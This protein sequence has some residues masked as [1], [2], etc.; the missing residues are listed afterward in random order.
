MNRRK[1]RFFVE[2][3]VMVMFPVALLVAC[4]TNGEG[5]ST[6]AQ[7]SV[8][9]HERTAVIPG[10]VETGAL[11]FG[12]VLPELSSE[13]GSAPAWSLDRQDVEMGMASPSLQLA[14]YKPMQAGAKNVATSGSVQ[15]VNYSEPEQLEKLDHYTFHFDTDDYNIGAANLAELKTHAEFLKRY[16]N[17]TLTISG[18]TD[19]SGSRTYNQKLSEQRAQLVAEVLKTHG[20]SASQLIVD[21]YGE[22]VPVSENAAENRRVEL[23]YT[24]ALLLSAM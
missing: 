11:P 24:Q 7:T 22:T 9:T 16:P 3:F 8:V 19:Q 5:T 2:T 20:V 6:A 13:S 18:H 1:E 4:T 15:M 21:G 14:V 23:E 10:Y 17:F 12:N